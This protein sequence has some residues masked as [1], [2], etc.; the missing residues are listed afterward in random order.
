LLNGR[1]RW[2][3]S[4]WWWR[5]GW[6]SLRTTIGCAR[7]RLGWRRRRFRVTATTGQ[8]QHEQ[9]KPTTEQFSHSKFLEFVKSG[10]LQVDI[11]Y[12]RLGIE[13]YKQ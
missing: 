3:F 11:G 7:W 1:I 5:W 2:L 9:Q 12:W 8:H 6:R 10:W 4:G 13:S